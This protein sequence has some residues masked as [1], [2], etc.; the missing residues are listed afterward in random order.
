ME[1]DQLQ[2]KEKNSDP[3]R[4]GRTSVRHSTRTVPTARKQTKRI[5]F[6]DKERGSWAR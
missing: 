6:D 5:L 1:E 2:R 4:P 3:A